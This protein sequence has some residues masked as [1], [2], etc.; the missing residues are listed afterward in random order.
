MQLILN[1]YVIK[2]ILDIIITKFLLKITIL[3]HSL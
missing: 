3:L 1:V 2:Y